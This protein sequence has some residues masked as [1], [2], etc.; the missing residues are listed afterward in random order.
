MLQHASLIIQCYNIVFELY[1]YAYQS[2]EILFTDYAKYQYCLGI[3]LCMVY[4]RTYGSFSPTQYSKGQVGERENQCV[5][6]HTKAYIMVEVL[7]T[8]QRLAFPHCPL[9]KHHQC[10][11]GLGCVWYKEFRALSL[12]TGK[13]S[14]GQVGE[15]VRILE[16]LSRVGQRLAFPHCL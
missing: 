10:V 13:H 1:W 16:V 7:S 9:A 15:K 11:Q 2:C 3:G 12:C 8:G 14:K 4:T 6:C 5:R